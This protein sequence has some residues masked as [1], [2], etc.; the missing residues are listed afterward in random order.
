M[1]N[2]PESSI[3]KI[4]ANIFFADKDLNL[5]YI[6]QKA[7]TTLHA[8]ASTLKKVFNLTPD[9][10][11]GQNLD[12]FH[13]GKAA[14]IRRILADPA[15]FPYKSEIRFGKIILELNINITMDAQGQIE[16]YIVNWDEITDKLEFQKIAIRSQQMV[17]NTPINTM[18]A[19]TDGSLL[20]MNKASEKTF[21]QIESLLPTKVDQMIGKS[22]DIYHKDPSRVRK[23]FSDPA[24]LPHSA[25]IRLGKE[26]LSLKV[27][28]LLGVENEFVGPMTTWELV[29]DKINLIGE[30]NESSRDLVK[31]AETLESIANSLSSSIEET[32][33]QAES[34][35]SASEEVNAGV[36]VVKTSMNQLV[37]AIQ[38]ITKSTNDATA[39]SNEAM[40]IAKQTNNVI[41]KLGAS[42]MDI[43]NVIKVISSIAQ[44]TNLLALNA[45]IEAARA[46]EAGKGFAVVANE[47]KELAKQTAKA[48][49]EITEKIENIQKDSK[50]AVAAIAKIT[51]SIEN[52]NSMANNIASAVEEQ[53]A[54]TNEVTRVVTESAQGVSTITQNIFQVSEAAKD[55]RKD[56]GQ[57]KD[58]AIQLKEISARLQSHINS[59]KVD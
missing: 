51:D 43:G 55:T 17:D 23:I 15:N 9:E 52:I 49:N 32:T 59:L 21:R 37:E 58:F 57:A 53:A 29:T 48:T 46:G 33:S 36:Q 38:E 42:S 10:I 41:D 22:I 30:L 4:Q 6:N 8:L 3:D 16:G 40:I 28:A 18:L 5:I 24:N 39:K 34:A 1:A 11:Q 13:K 14:Q 12:L 2:I 56:A 44:Q 45:T 19:D 27:T 7:K 50:D 25:V 31:A 26:H 47:V 54:T 35:T 20:Y